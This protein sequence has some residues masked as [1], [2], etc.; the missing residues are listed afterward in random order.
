MSGI[1]LFALGPPRLERNGQI[2]HIERHKALALLAYLVVTGE[3]HRRDALAALFW[4][5]YDQS[6]ARAALRRTLS[7]LNT[8]LA[9]DVLDAERERI[10]LRDDGDATLWVDVAQF[11]LLLST[12][13]RHDHAATGVCA[14]CL[15]VLAQ[16]AVLYRGDFL[17]GFTLRDSADFDDWQIFQAESLRRELAGALEQ[18]V[19]GHSAHREFETAIGYARRWVALDPLHEPA[20][21]ALIALYAWAGQRQTALR[22]YA[23][24]ARVLERE[25]GAPPQT[26]TTQLYTT[27]KENR[28]P[29]LPETPA[30]VR[31]D[32]EPAASAP[33]LPAP[34]QPSAHTFSLFDRMVRG[35]L[36]G[37]ERESARIAAIWQQVSAGHGCALLVSG[38]AGIGKTRLGREAVAL[39]TNVGASVLVGR[40][41][42][43][44]AAPFTPIAQWVACALGEAGDALRTTPGYILADLLTLAP[45]LRPRF[46]Q[47]TLNPT[48]DPELERQRIFDSFVAWCRRLAAQS[49]L[50][51]WVEDIHWADSGT[52][53][54]LRYLAQQMQDLRLLLLLTYRD[55]ELGLAEGR[56]LGE[57]LAELDRGR[58]TETVRLTRLSRDQTRRLLATLLATPDEISAEFLASIYG[59]TEGNPFFIEEVC[60]TLIEEGKLYFAGGS[61]RRTDIKSVLIPR[62]IRAAILGRVERLP[63]AHQE[64]LRAAAVLGREFDVATLRALGGWDEET[65]IGML[66]HLE[67]T[68][69]ITEAQRTTPVRYAFAHALIPFTLRENLSGL[70][71]Q[72]VHGRAAAALEA[73]H[74]DDFEALAYHFTAAGE[75]SKAIAYCRQAAQRA[76]SLYA[77]DAAIQH[78]H[79]A[80]NLLEDEA[81]NGER[82]STLEQLADVHYLAGERGEAMQHYADALDLWRSQADGER[83]SGVRL[84]RKI[85]E[86]HLHLESSV[87]I[88]RF[89]TTVQASRELGL[90]LIADALPHPEAVRLLATLADDAR[91][92]QRG[93]DWVVAERYAQAAVAMAEQLAA[94]AELALALAALETVYGVL[95][96]LRE[97]VSLALAGVALSRDP[98]FGNKQEQCRLLIEAGN[99]LLLV[100]DYAQA[101]VHLAEAEVLADQM[102]DV[103]RQVWVLGLQAQCFFGLDRWDEM[104]QIENKRQALEDRYGHHRV[105]IMCFYCGLRAN[106]AALRGDYAAARQ[107][108][109]VAFN[110]M[111]NFWDGPPESGKWSGAG[112]Y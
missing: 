8:A 30:P 83:W 101:L 1:K 105:G 67:R 66:E 48:L 43:E 104:L 89:A 74:P 62:S 91:G 97:R 98:A 63:T 18:L 45:Q 59:E 7:A 6:R 102:R 61:W 92:V 47:I 25:L 3:H 106:V 86:T 87:Q 81:S 60:K 28:P 112:H 78:L 75:R 93:Q 16:A 88:D 5:E 108:R 77:Y 39:A 96:R 65:L 71:L 76:R 84:C 13:R 110:N 80:L 2:M 55:D 90:A 35:Q 46:P 57:L 15:P 40:C 27:I 14:D 26:A 10:G 41:D 32:P 38:E 50:L 56:G 82:L 64:L 33:A 69:L 36:V 99:A 42:A 20:Q 107:F 53:S 79:T 44:R 85:S 73:L 72:R 49:P 21:R 52:L 31:P 100:G 70:R 37:R 22:Q 34:Q 94:P 51:L 9:E 68:Q 111:A 24:C 95:G 17:A 58:L 12:C 54:L 19:R 103:T 11:R 109:E 29:P 23:E 4:P